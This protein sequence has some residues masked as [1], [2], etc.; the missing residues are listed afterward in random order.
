MV[1]RKGR[2]LS[3]AEQSLWKSV[4]DTARPLSPN[5]MSPEGVPGPAP[6]RNPPVF[7]EPMTQIG[8]VAKPQAR[9]IPAP[10]PVKDLAQG[11]AGLDG[12]TAE[13][14]RKGK[15]APEARIDL[16]GYT[17]DRAHGALNAFMD[18]A[19]ARG[20]RCVLVITGKGRASDE[21]GS[22]S[23]TGVLRRNV[24]RWLGQA[25]HASHVVGVYPAHPRHGGGG[26]FY[27]YL[28]KNRPTRR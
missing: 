1:K 28:R 18:S 11:A 23:E 8:H 21:P 25:P 12:R 15:L 3:E 19:R 16:H 24:P 17:A 13:R 6:K 2:H 26:A 14:L 22:Y 27:V 20:L 4:T 10:S 9:F 7:Q 5:P